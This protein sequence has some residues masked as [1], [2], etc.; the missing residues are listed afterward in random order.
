MLGFLIILLCMLVCTSLYSM[1][2]SLNTLYDLEN[3]KGAVFSSVFGSDTCDLNKIIVMR[4]NKDV[5]ANFVVSVSSILERSRTVLR[6]V[7]RSWNQ[8]K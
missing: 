5:S 1:E 3:D 2:F 6:Y 7:L 4:I 8:T